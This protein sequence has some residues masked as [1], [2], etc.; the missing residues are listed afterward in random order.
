MFKNPTKD[1]QT[2]LLVTQQECNEK[3]QIF[4]NGKCGETCGNNEYVKDNDCFGYSYIKTKNECNKSGTKGGVFKAG[5][6]TTDQ[7]CTPCT[8]SRGIIK[9]NECVKAPRTARKRR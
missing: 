2:C 8:I 6:A 3:R 7:T 4:I 9:N 5:T 1:E